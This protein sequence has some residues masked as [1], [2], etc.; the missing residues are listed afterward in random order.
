MT[1]SIAWQ[2][3][4]GYGDNDP[5]QDGDLTSSDKLY[6]EATKDWTDAERKAYWDNQHERTNSVFSGLGGGLITV[7]TGAIAVGLSPMTSVVA[8]AVSCYTIIKMTYPKDT[9]DLSL[10]ENGAFL[11]R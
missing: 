11:A 1:T 3:D 6:I 5:L 2:D 9:I 10:H 4:P 8:G 7:A